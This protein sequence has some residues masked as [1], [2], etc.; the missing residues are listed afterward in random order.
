MAQAKL[1]RCEQKE[2]G[3][4]LTFQDDGG[5]EFSG[6]YSLGNL[7]LEQMQK[8]IGNRVSFSDRED[9]LHVHKAWNG[10]KPTYCDDPFHGFDR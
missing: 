6:M 7:S 9:G 8:L 5:N 1:I 4:E 3:I 2:N 10:E